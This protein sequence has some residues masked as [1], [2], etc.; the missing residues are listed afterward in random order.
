MFFLAMTDWIDYKGELNK[1][2]KF[3]WKTVLDRSPPY[4][5]RI[6][7]QEFNSPKKPYI[8]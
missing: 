2:T 7:L 3:I 1:E 4:L 5:I 6:I 8:K